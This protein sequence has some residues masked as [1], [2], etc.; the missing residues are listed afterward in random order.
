MPR[1]RLAAIGARLP[2]S[3]AEVQK[4]LLGARNANDRFWH[5]PAKTDVCFSAAPEG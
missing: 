3:C 5:N 2:P 4:L 1:D